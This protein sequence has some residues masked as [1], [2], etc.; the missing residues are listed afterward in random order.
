MSTLKLDPASLRNQF[1]ALERIVNDQQAVFLDGPGG[2][3]SP[4]RVIGAVTNY[5]RQGSSNQGGPF[6]TSRET[7]AITESAREAMRD[8]AQCP[9]AGGNCLRS[10][11]DQP[12]IQCQ[13]GDSPNLEPG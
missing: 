6:L 9:T 2:T 12:D 13:P 3:Q 8:F 10:E 5:L 7:D 11:Y 4:E 1:P